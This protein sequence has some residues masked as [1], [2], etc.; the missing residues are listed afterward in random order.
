[1][2]DLQLGGFHY[3]WS[4]Y[5]HGYSQIECNSDRVLVNGAFF[6]TNYYKG[7]T[8]LPGLLDHSPII[9][10]QMRKSS[11]RS[12]FRYFSFWARCPGFFQV[13]SEAWTPHVRGSALFRVV[14]K[15]KR[16][17]CALKEWRRT[18]IPLHASIQVA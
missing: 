7:E 1:M 15:Q 11:C 17:K 2:E 9:F 12:P 14:T 6:Q 13:V 8:M 10:N 5:G 18:Q 16:V 3:S 4:N